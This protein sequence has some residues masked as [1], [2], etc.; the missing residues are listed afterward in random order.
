MSI[1]LD[2][3]KLMPLLAIMLMTGCNAAGNPAETTIT[4][5][6]TLITEDAPVTETTK[7]NTEGWNYDPAEVIV[8]YDSYEEFAD[9]M[10][11]RFPDAFLYQLPEGSDF[12]YE[13]I[14]LHDDAFYHL[15]LSDGN[16][17][18]VFL[19]VLFLST[20]DSIEDVQKHF[21]GTAQIEG[22]TFEVAA[23]DYLFEQY[24][25]GVVTL[26]G[27]AGD[28]RTLFTMMDISDETPD[29]PELKKE[30]LTAFYE[31]LGL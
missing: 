7:F 20:Y 22:S 23:P 30:R 27:L 31:S 1:F 11:E 2:M 28:E 12:Q 16:G 8:P 19:E 17:N 13:K 3:Y 21:G 18:R 9:M 24:G 6:T 4:A 5:E 10:R 26:M 25:D 29:D 14:S 15:T